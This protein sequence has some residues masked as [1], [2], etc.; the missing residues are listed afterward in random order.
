MLRYLGDSLILPMNTTR[1]SDALNEYINDLKEGY[2]KA[3]EAHDVKLGRLKVQSA[4]KSFKS[5]SM[6][7]A[8]DSLWWRTT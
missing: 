4:P 7:I 8:K 6:K 5:N 3:M 1:Y 2:G